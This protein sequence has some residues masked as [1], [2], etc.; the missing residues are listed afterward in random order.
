MPSIHARRWYTK[1]AARLAAATAA[2]LAAALRP[3]RTAPAVRVLTY[4]DFGPSRRDPFRVEPAELERQVAW[5]A[6]QGL[7]V[8]LGDVRAFLAGRRSLRD[9]AV[10][11]TIDDGD[12]GVASHAWPILARHGV[13]A[14]AFIIAGEMGRPGRMSATQVRELAAAGLE[15]GS[16]SLTHPSMARIDRRQAEREAVESRFLLEDTIGRPVT[17][18]AYPYGTLAD[19]D[20]AVASILAGAGYDCAF[21]SQHGPIRPGMPA[22][23]LPRVKVEGGDPGWL[24][25]QLCRGRLDCWRLV[26]RAL[27]RA[28]RP[29]A[30]TASARA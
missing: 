27:W 25:P 13:P 2:G 24:F 17:A 23:T 10:L 26:D 8:S 29:H 30:G 11:I 6:E 5:L 3:T 28:Q 15:I 21:T 20:D 4:H 19:Y 22:L 12:A 7:A 1:K 9:G 16:H 18:F 14:V